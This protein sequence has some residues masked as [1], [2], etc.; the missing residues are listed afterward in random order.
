MAYLKIV[1]AG[2][3]ILKENAKPVKTITKNIKRMLDDMAQ[4]M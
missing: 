4:T 3:P 2:D 1:K